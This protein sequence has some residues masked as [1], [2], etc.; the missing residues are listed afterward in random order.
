MTFPEKT[1]CQTELFQSPTT[2]TCSAVWGPDLPLVTNWCLV[3]LSQ[4]ASSDSEGDKEQCRSLKPPHWRLQTHVVRRVC[5]QLMLLKCPHQI[6]VVFKAEDH[7]W[8]VKQDGK[9]EAP[10][11][12]E[13]EFNHTCW[14]ITWPRN[15][16]SSRNTQ[17]DTNLMLCSLSL[18][19]ASKL[20][21]LFMLCGWSV[22]RDHTWS[23]LMSLVL[24]QIQIFGVTKAHLTIE[25]CL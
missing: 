13:L 14:L 25:E 1:G 24:P 5:F 20:Q 8:K 11:S 2:T 19:A 4:E 16:S 12:D 23:V 15:T 17:I 3:A 6:L 22:F 9:Q 18:C 21:A 7:T 10:R